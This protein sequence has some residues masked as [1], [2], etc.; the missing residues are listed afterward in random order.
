MILPYQT[1]FETSNS[2]N[3]SGTS[4]FQTTNG[5]ATQP[6]FSSPTSAALGGGLAGLG[7]FNGLN[8]SSGSAGTVPPVTGVS[9]PDINALLANLAQTNPS[10]LNF[11]NGG[12]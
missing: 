1:D 8:G 10:V 9:F 11:M 7:I 3:Q 2:G 4:G 12:N 6:L 5:S